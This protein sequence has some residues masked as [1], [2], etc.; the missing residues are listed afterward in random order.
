MHNTMDAKTWGIVRTK[1]IFFSNV[2]KSQV[3]LGGFSLPA[4][5]VHSKASVVDTAGRMPFTGFAEP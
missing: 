5:R 4:G 3:L 1:G 2:K